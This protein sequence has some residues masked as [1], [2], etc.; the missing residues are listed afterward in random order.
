MLLVLCGVC[1]MMFCFVVSGL[2][3]GVGGFGVKGLLVFAEAS[4][5]L[6]SLVCMP[7]GF[8]GVL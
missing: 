7:L 2:A 3:E 1:L 6:S 5:G 8:R 4:E